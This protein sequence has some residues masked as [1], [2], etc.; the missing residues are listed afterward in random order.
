VQGCRFLS[1]ERLFLFSKGGGEAADRD[2]GLNGAGTERPGLLFDGDSHGSAGQRP[3]IIEPTEA[4]GTQGG[5]GGILQQGG[6]LIGFRVV[7]LIDEGGL[8]QRRS[9]LFEHGRLF[10]GDPLDVFPFVLVELHEPF[11]ERLDVEYRDGE[12]ADATMGTAGSTRDRSEQGG[13]SS[14]KP[15]VGLALELR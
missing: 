13:V 1:G 15:A 2:E 14:L 7:E 8:L 4:F 6:Q 3:M 5:A 10:G 12:R 11:L 9:S